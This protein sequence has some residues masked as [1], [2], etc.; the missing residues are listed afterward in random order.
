MIIILTIKNLSVEEG[1]KKGVGAGRDYVAGLD[2]NEWL[3]Q[4]VIMYI[5]GNFRRVTSVKDIQ[6][7]LMCNRNITCH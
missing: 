7:I 3:F 2:G 6:K 5:D 4:K 1:V